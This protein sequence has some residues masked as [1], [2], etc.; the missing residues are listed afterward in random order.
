M[1]TPGPVDE[2]SSPGRRVVIAG[3]VGN[4]LEWYDFAVFGYL[5]HTI[6]AHFF[7]SSDPTVSLLGAFGVFAG[8]YFMRPIGAVIFGHVGDSLGRKRA[9]QAS[10]LLMAVPTAAL[11]VASA[12]LISRDRAP[13]DMWLT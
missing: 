2:R 11:P 8:A 13:N 5:A 12:V 1:S 10:V 9:L 6:G 4:V 7:P 3:I